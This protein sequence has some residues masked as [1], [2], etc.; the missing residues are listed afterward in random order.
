MGEPAGKDRS[1]RRR[2]SPGTRPTDDELLDAARAVFAERGFRQ[3][4]MDAVAERA[5]STKPTLYAHFGDKLALYQAA[6]AR[7][8][9][10]LRRWVVEAYRSA[11]GLD[12]AGRVR[13]YVMALFDY[14]AA[15]P[16]SFRMLFDATTTDETTTARQAVVD[17][18]TGRVAEEID[19]ALA[20]LGRE[21]GPSPALLAAMMV[22]LCGAAARHAL[23]H[24]LDPGAAGELA[25]SFITA[26]L[27][28]LEPT[29]LDALDR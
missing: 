15:N 12:V 2:R 8:S 7:E 1:T 19:R 17:V 14:A 3:A 23:H 27:T 13:V 26:A 5:N 18:I 11:P 25:A 21:P 4:T 29:I 24:D 9:E 6:F 28:S 20:D 16:Q 22:G 10:A